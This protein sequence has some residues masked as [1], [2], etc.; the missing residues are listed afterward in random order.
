MFHW[1]NLICLEDQIPFIVNEVK[2]C[3]LFISFSKKYLFIPVSW[4]PF[5]VSLFLLF[6]FRTT[7]D[8]SRAHVIF[9]L[10]LFLSWCVWNCLISVRGS[11]KHRVPGKMCESSSC[12]NPN[13]TSEEE[14]LHMWLHERK[15]RT[16]G[17]KTTHEWKYHVPPSHIPHSS[18]EKMSFSKKKAV[19]CKLLRTVHTLYI[20]LILYK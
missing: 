1:M 6:F 20:V 8:D 3:F 7:H 14:T 10:I 4:P 17:E 5:L 9:S 12:P 15:R 13:T 2:I 16:S 11:G 18:S 19:I